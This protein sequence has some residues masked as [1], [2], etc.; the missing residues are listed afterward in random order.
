[1]SFEQH[2]RKKIIFACLSKVFYFTCTNLVSDRFCI[3]WLIWEMKN[4]ILELFKTF[5]LEVKCF[6]VMFVIFICFWI[7]YTLSDGFSSTNFSCNS[8]NSLVKWIL[9]FF[10]LSRVKWILRCKITS[11]CLF[12]FSEG[13]FLGVN[14]VPGTSFDL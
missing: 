13:F 1:M 7:R 12:G 10:F 11:K 14:L 6:C 9:F 2:K 3:R 8:E 4:W 5:I